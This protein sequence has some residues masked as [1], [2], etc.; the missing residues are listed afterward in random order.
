MSRRIE[1]VNGLLRR[2]IGEL[3]LTGLRDPRLAHLVSIVTV[4]TSVD[5]HYATVRYSVMGPPEAK[6]EVLDGLN[7]AIPYIRR[8]LRARL[9]IKFIPELHFVLDDT[10]ERADRVLRIM[11]SLDNQKRDAKR[12]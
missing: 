12:G 10:M 9:D 8:E 4:D 1:R 2:E 3:L 6:Q 5:L 11:D 7:S